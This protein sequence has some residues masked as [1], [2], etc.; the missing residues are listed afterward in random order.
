MVSLGYSYKMTI[1]STRIRILLSVALISFGVLFR[2]IPHPVN[3]APIGAIAL[4]GGS[5]L[6]KRYAVSV[7]VATM[8]LSDVLIGFHGVMA[9]TW[10]SYLLIALLGG[11]VLQ[12]TS[13]I[14]IGGMALTSSF[15]FFTI[16]NFGVWLHSGMYTK[17]IDGLIQCY[18]MALPFY[19]NTLIGDVFFSSL[20]FGGYTVFAVVK[21]S[22]ST[23]LQPLHVE[24]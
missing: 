23:K 12:K 22:L 6:P 10:G 4:F 5:K 16:S 20:L 2:L 24:K 7:I 11:F 9:Y 8:L 13:V 19:Q 1:T 15:L 14:K 18:I 21:Y 3:I 17:T